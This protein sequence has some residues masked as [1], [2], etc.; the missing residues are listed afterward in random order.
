MAPCSFVTVQRNNAAQLD[1]LLTLVEPHTHER[2]VL[3]QG[4]TDDSEAVA[5]RHGATWIKR[6]TAFMADPD[7]NFAQEIAQQPWVLTFDPDERPVA[8]FW[9]ALPALCDDEQADVYTFVCEHWVD[10]V[11][12]AGGEQLP[13]LYRRGAVAY[14]PQPHT[15][16]Q[17]QTRPGS[18]APRVV[19]VAPDIGTFLHCRMWAPMVA[20]NARRNVY[21]PQTQTVQG[22]FL[23]QARQTLDAWT[24]PVNQYALDVA[25]G[26]A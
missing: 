11:K 9:D 10:G 23:A 26:R 6:P 18:A 21:G 17:M 12:V 5:R 19:H 15:F 4:S 25:E 14:S 24:G 8:A 16:P 13:R 1:H 22:H 3:D 2:I 20:S 7:R